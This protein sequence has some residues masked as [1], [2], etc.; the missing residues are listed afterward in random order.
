MSRSRTWALVGFATQY[1]KTCTYT[2]WSTPV[3]FLSCALER[4]EQPYI[5]QVAPHLTPDKHK[6]ALR[7]CQIIYSESL[8]YAKISPYFIHGFL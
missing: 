3:Q 4:G 2:V 1:F 5:Y 6:G 7:T 8:T